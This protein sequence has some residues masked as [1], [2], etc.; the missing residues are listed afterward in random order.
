MACT[1]G[2]DALRLRQVAAANQHS[3]GWQLQTVTLARFVYAASA[4]RGNERRDE[5]AFKVFR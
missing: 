2:G 5:R 1:L 3:A 4:T